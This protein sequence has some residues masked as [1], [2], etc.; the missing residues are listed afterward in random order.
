M[1]ISLTTL[2]GTDSVASARI[3]INDNFSTISSALNSVLSI[4][5]IAT[6]LFDNTGYGSNNNIRTES[7]TATT[8]ITISSGNATI[9]NGNIV[10]SGSIQL[11]AG[12]NV[13]I[14]KSSHI[15]ASGTIYTVDV[16]GGTGITGSTP[17]GAL[18]LPRLETSSYEAIENP[19][20]GS[21]VYDVTTN[22]L[23]VCTNTSA[24][25]GATGTWVIIGEQIA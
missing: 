4:I 21:I 13:T 10:L 15:L 25:I 19:E 8:G 17:V 11:G 12:T 16:S 23:M 5:D 22:R 6:G 14:K 7:L 20:L 1:A 3:T 2:N 18:A 24:T 9:S